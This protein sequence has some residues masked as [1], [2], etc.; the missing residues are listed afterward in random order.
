MVSEWTPDKTY[1]INPRAFDTDV[2]GHES[3]ASASHLAFETAT[4]N[5]AM[6]PEGRAGS[7]YSV[8]PPYSSHDIHAGRAMRAIG[9]SD[10]TV[11]QWTGFSMPP[12]IPPAR[13]ASLVDDARASGIHADDAS[14]ECKVIGSSSSAP[15]LCAMLT[16]AQDA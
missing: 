12:V 13:D 2:S 16:M 1:P 14:C 15:R 6:L 3:H 10:D 8:F 9:E 11:Q 5:C 7:I 4:R